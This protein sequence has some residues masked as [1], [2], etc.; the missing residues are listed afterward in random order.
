MSIFHYFSKDEDKRSR[1]IFNFIAPIYARIGKSVS[2][3]YTDLIKIVDKFV[4]IEGKK[5]LDVGTGSGSWANKYHEFG[6][7][8]VVGV[9]SAIKMLDAGR[10]NF[11]HIEF[12]HCDAE[13]LSIFEE[14]SFDIVTASYVLHG[15]KKDRRLKMLEQMKR[16]TKKYVIVND[17]AGKVGLPIR[18]L[19]AIER[20]DMPYFKDHFI[21]E[22]KD[23][24]SYA[25]LLKLKGGA[26]LYIAEK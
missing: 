20:S 26:G 7:S 13:K 9:D 3:K 8:K 19:E 1:F 14:N 17:F 22:L 6:A 2:D 18:L 5:V 11:P 25:K 12:I 21:D 15:V 16:V 10:K 4:K 24:F 23:N